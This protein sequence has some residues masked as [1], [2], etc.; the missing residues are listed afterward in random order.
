MTYYADHISQK[1]VIPKLCQETRDTV[2]KKRN[3]A[4]FIAI[5]TDS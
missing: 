1:K 3:E 4:E 5:A 2:T